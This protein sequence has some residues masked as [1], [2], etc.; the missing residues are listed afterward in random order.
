MASCPSGQRVRAAGPRSAPGTPD[1][2]SANIQEVESVQPRPAAGDHSIQPGSRGR[3]GAQTSWDLRPHQHGGACPES[4]LL[5]WISLGEL[6]LSN[7]AVSSYPPV[8]CFSSMLRYFYSTTVLEA[9]FVHFT[10]LHLKL[11]RFVLMQ[12][13]WINYDVLEVIWGVGYFKH[14]LKT[15]CDSYAFLIKFSFDRN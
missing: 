10:P 11:C 5:W 3:H 8:L 13:K 12:N 4:R 7:G 9:D 2:H 1:T 15:N 6:G 14:I